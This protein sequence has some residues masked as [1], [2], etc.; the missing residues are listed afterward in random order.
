MYF[1]NE[2]RDFPL[3]KKPNM[4]SLPQHT[5]PA[6]K[7]AAFMTIETVEEDNEV[8]SSRMVNGE[9]AV[10]CLNAKQKWLDLLFIA[11]KS[12][13][14]TLSLQTFPCSSLASHK[15]LSQKW[16]SLN[17][18]DTPAHID[19]PVYCVPPIGL[20]CRCCRLQVTVECKLGP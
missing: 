3:K 4:T 11:V 6:W 10:I 18:D 5:A 9:M 20:R 19:T 8:F 14:A 2:S 12:L 13:N 7:Q 1:D 15:R 16:S 17:I